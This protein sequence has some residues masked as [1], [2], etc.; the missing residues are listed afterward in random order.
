MNKLLNDIL[1]ATLFVAITFLPLWVWL[2]M[3]NP[4]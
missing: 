3:M 4:L 2:A 1:C